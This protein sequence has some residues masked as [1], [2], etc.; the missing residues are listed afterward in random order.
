MRYDL[1]ESIRGNLFLEVKTLILDKDV[2][3]EDK[4]KLK[5]EYI[6]KTEKLLETVK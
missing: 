4:I 2:E 1:D 3:D 5:E 6:S